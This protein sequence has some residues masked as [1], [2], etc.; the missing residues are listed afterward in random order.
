[1]SYSATNSTT[2][3]CIIIIVKTNHMLAS[4]TRA[5]H[6][7]TASRLF[8]CPIYIPKRCSKIT[9]ELHLPCVRAIIFVAISIF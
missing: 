6:L 2:K 5:R 1:M 4:E 3:T 9:L 8:S 7:V